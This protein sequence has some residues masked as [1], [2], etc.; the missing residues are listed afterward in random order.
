MYNKTTFSRRIA[1]IIKRDDMKTEIREAMRGGP[2]TAQLIHLVQKEEMKNC[3]F[4]SEI[5]LPPGTGIGKH[6]HTDETE[7]FIIT[8]G[9]G[10][11]EDNGKETF[12]KA[13]DVLL[14]PHGNTHSITNKGSVNLKMIALI[15]TY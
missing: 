7:Y 14:T 15:I 11:V 4:M 1:M 6:E 2:G 3:R 9:E 12:I 8:A 13:G 10:V 5:I